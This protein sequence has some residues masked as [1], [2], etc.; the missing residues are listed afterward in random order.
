MWREKRIKS[1]PRLQEQMK[2]YYVTMFINEGRCRVHERIT[3][4]VYVP[5]LIC[6]RLCVMS[7][8]VYCIM[9]TY[10]YNIIRTR[11][12]DIVL[13]LGRTHT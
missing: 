12:F 2:T 13:K 3:A 10:V 1:P 7:T 6:F 9:R 8:R 5:T 4:A 11:A